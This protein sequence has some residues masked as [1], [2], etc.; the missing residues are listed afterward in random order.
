MDAGHLGDDAWAQAIPGELPTDNTLSL[1]YFFLI[2]SIPLTFLGVVIREAENSQIEVRENE[3]QF[4]MTNSAPVMIWKSDTEKR[5]TFFNKGW[6]DF[7]GRTLEQEQGYGWAEGVHPEDYKR[8]LQV[9]VD[10]FDVRQDFTMEYR[11][12][13]SDGE[14]RWVLDSG[15]PRFDPHGLFQ[16]Y[17]GSCVDIT[18]SKRAELEIQQH[19][20]ELAHLSRVT[21]MG[22]LSG[23]MA[24]ELNQPLAAILCN[25]QAALRFLALD[26]VNLEDLREI[27]KD[28][29]EED[30]ARGEVIRGLRLLFKKG[31]VQFQPLELNGVIEEV[32]KLLHSD[33]VN[34][35]IVVDRNLAQKLPEVSGDRVQLQQVLINLILNGCDAMANTKP[36]DRRLWLQTESNHGQVVK[37]TVGDHGCGIAPDR[38]GKV[39]E[40]FVSTKPNGMGMGLAVCKTIISAHD[41]QLWAE[42]NPGT[43]ACFAF[44]LP[45]L[46]KEAK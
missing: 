36:S 38:L 33:L 24:H 46:R 41:G 21:M 37:V 28:I 5:C 27:L 35:N 43:G 42:S 40:P 17:I 34:H 4:R 3:A 45:V 39:F 2:I 19:R 22:E 10:S 1:Q 15:V 13:R 11:L 16:G 26:T 7:T 29:A 6:L 44:A 31:E 9:Y 25:A 32:L 18:T 8:C 14:Y 30:S 20:S 23:S 12:R